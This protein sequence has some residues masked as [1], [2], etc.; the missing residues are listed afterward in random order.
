M[1]HVLL[2]LLMVG[3]KTDSEPVGAFGWA[4]ID[5]D[6]RDGRRDWA[7]PDADDDDRAPLLLEANR[8]RA[9]SLKLTLSDA[10]DVRVWLDGVVILDAELRTAEVAYAKEALP[11]EVEFGDYNVDVSLEIVEQNGGG[12]AMGDPWSVPLR[13]GPLLLNHHLLPAIQVQSVDI[14]GYTP[15]A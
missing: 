13:S 1:R 11:L 9:K 3:C 7:A 5:D 10:K 2:V 8:R 14:T 6:D 12:K 4:N 15:A